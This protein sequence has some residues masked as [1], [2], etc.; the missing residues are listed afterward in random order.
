MLSKGYKGYNI[1]EPFVW[2]RVG[3]DMYKRRGGW[4]YVG[5]QRRLFQYMARIGFITNRQCQLQGLIRLVGA[6]IPSWLRAFLFK[7]FLRK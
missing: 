5:S 1:E 6:V 3:Q 7:N 4:R 2:V